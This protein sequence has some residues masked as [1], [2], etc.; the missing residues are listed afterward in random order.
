MKSVFLPRSPNW[1]ST[2][3]G[4]CVLTTADS[5]SDSMCLALGF[6]RC[7]FNRHTEQVMGFRFLSRPTAARRPGDVGSC[8]RG[9]DPNIGWAC[10]CMGGFLLLV[11]SRSLLHVGVHSHS[12][13]CFFGLLA[14]D[15]SDVACNAWACTAGLSGPAQAASFA[16]SSVSRRWRSRG[17]P[18]CRK[19]G[20]L[21]GLGQR[22]VAGPL[23][24]N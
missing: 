23:K 20:R 8:S 15:L 7:A 10:Y 12:C 19:S 21:G 17:F 18:N 22:C 2:T 5:S 1:A 4:W 16:S 14:G 9:A 6:P 3:R 11:S 24:I 13:V